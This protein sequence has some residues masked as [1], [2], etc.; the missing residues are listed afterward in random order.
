MSRTIILAITVVYLLI[1]IL[2]AACRLASEVVARLQPNGAQSATLNPDWLVTAAELNGFS[3]GIGIV[4]WRVTEDMPGENR[5]CRIFQG[6]SWSVGPN[7]AMNCVN[8]VFGGSNFE[9]VIA[10]LFDAGLLLPDD[11]ELTPTLPHQHDFAL[12]T[13][14]AGNGHTVYDA[15][16]LADGRLFRASVTLGTPLGSTPESL[17]A[18][19]GQPIETF[20]TEMLTL[21]LKRVS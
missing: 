3:A 10:S 5:I 12:Y 19:Q 9:Q 14:R 13:H 7:T 15:F 18:A 8:S 4:E 16:L 21:N 6:E 11:I 1:N 20:L 17:F 2:S